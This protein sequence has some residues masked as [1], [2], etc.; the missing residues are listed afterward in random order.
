M[1]HHRIGSSTPQL[2]RL[3]LVAC[4]LFWSSFSAHKAHAETISWDETLGFWNLADN[5]SPTSVPNFG[6]TAIISNGG[7]SVVSS[8][9]FADNLR[10][11]PGSGVGGTLIIDSATLQTKSASLASGSGG[12]GSILIENN[13]S[14]SVS[15][16]NFNV[17]TEAGSGTLNLT[18]RS[19]GQVEVQQGQTRIGA[20]DS[21]AFVKIT[22]SGSSLTTSFAPI[23]IRGSNTTFEL[24]E[25]A[26]LFS[27][28]GTVS[29]DESD[30]P[31]VIVT[32]DGVGTLW[33]A[34]SDADAL[35]F[36]QN[37]NFGIGDGAEVRATDFRFETTQQPFQPRLIISG[38]EGGRGAW[39]RVTDSATIT[40]ASG[41][42]GPSVDKPSAKISDGGLLS[43]S[44]LAI[45]NT[46][47][48]L[49]NNGR[50]STVNEIAIDGG[51]L[52]LKGTLDS[53]NLN[54][55][56]IS[57][58]NN[59]ELSLQHTADEFVLGPTLSG[60]LALVVGSTGTTVLTQANSHT[61]GT[62]VRGSATL[63][64]EAD[65][66]LGTGMVEVQENGTLDLR[67]F[68]SGPIDLSESGRI[69][70]TFSAFASEPQTVTINSDIPSAPGNRATT[71]EISLL[72]SAERIVEFSTSLSSSATN[73]ASRRSNIISI[74][75]TANDPFV[76]QIAVSPWALA[77]E[78]YVAW[79]D[80]GEFVLATNGNTGNNASAQQMDFAGDFDTFVA[81]F[82]SDFSQYIGA[83]GGD[84]S[85]GQFW[86]VSNHNSDFALVPE[87]S[88]GW[89]VALAALLIIPLYR[90]C[91]SALKTE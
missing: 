72:A 36:S 60:S 32:A 43:A 27:A 23:I 47:V 68:P 5:W 54:A 83:Y 70:G 89:L 46:A 59:S 39:L 52:E 30:F 88:G 90:R 79:L 41:T 69:T 38:M 24:L 40:A 80:N 64:V 44:T 84:A 42:D 8:A 33:R 85:S 31:V 11:A 12:S 49:E 35:H 57:G 19:G 65:D 4:V 82:G 48:V 50:V 77:E 73:D 55:S 21:E 2:L 34:T 74:E 6:D 9:A 75:G 86:A 63:I 87:P 7:T 3:G 20:P 45:D 91:R 18:V 62:V 76:L 67:S 1:N 16:G 10:V 26:S 29:Q 37:T 81:E 28:G 25:G 66:A 15:E 61:N 78:G 13:G 14:L 71:A 53:A 22:G 58:T 51:I 17:A 56:S